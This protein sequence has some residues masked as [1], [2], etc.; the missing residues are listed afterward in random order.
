MESIYIKHFFRCMLLLFVLQSCFHSKEEDSNTLIINEQT[1]PYTVKCNNILS[2]SVAM[3]PLD[4]ANQ[5]FKHINRF[6]GEPFNLAMQMPDAWTVECSLPSFSPDFAIWIIANSGEATIKLL[7][8]ITTTE[9]PTVIQALPIAYSIAIEKANYIESELW[10]ADIDNSY[11]IV[12][13]KKYERLYSIIEENTDN[14]SNTITKKDNYTIELDGKIAYQKPETFAIDYNAIIQF[15]DTSVVGR[16]DEDWVL[17]SIEIQE[18]IES[19]GILFVTVTS[20]FDR[21]EITNYYGEIVDIVDISGFIGKHDMGYLA[22]KKGEKT[23]FIPYATADK[24]LQKAE[25]YFKLEIVAK[26]EEEEE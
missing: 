14:K 3:L 4:I 19:L 25:T 11:N 22:L 6:E 2:D 5:L 1:L 9:E 26:N 10:F 24:C 13:T 20:A 7:A 15:A 16:L 8:T 18:Q 17:N 23:L 21:V 12:V